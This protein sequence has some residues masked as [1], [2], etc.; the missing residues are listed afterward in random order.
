MILVWVRLYVPMKRLLNCAE[1]H[2]KLK[3]ALAREPI[4]LLLCISG[5]KISLALYLMLILLCSLLLYYTY[6][7]ATH[8]ILITLT[9]MHKIYWC[10]SMAYTISFPDKPM[11]QNN[12]KIESLSTWI[13]H[14]KGYSFVTPVSNVSMQTAVQ[15]QHNYGPLEF[16]VSNVSVE[17]WIQCD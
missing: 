5:Y 9:W 4:M 16:I 2:F 3:L 6:T 11:Q 8:T 7:N 14:L 17:I 12:G 13:L 1:F 10:Y 15:R